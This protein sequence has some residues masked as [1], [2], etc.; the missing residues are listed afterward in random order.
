MLYIRDRE[1]RYHSVVLKYLTVFIDSYISMVQ[2]GISSN[3]RALDLH[4]RGTGIDTRILHFSLFPPT[5]ISDMISK[6]HELKG[7]KL[8]LPYFR[9]IQISLISIIEKIFNN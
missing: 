8:D 7:E 1:T 9:N 5:L 3:G 4:S 6:G 2:R